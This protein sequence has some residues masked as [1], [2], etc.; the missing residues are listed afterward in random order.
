VIIMGDSING[1]FTKVTTNGSL[2]YEGDATRWDDLRVP[3]SSTR[4]GAA[5]DPLYDQFKNDGSGS[6]GVYGSWFRTNQ[7]EDLF[8]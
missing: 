5:E 2:S 1:N 3:M 8:F 6:V 4:R 7:T